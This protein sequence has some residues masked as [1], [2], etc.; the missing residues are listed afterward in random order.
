[1]LHVD[2][3]PVD[4]NAVLPTPRAC[5][6]LFFATVMALC[7]VPRTALAQVDDPS[8]A[9]DTSPKWIVLPAV[10][11]S[12]ETSMQFGGLGVVYW[13]GDTTDAVRDGDTLSRL[14]LVGIYTLKR[15]LLLRALSD[16]RFQG[17]AW[18]VVFE[19]GYERFPDRYFGIGAEPG[20]GGDED[21]DATSIDVGFDLTRRLGR[22]LHLGPR[23]RLLSTEV[24]AFAEGGRFDRGEVPGTRGVASGL[25]ISATWDQRDHPTDTR[26]G[27]YAGGAVVPFNAAFGSDRA[28]TRIDADLRGYLTLP[29]AM[30]LAGQL[31]TQF[32]PGSPGFADMA[33]LGGSDLLRGIYE[34]HFRDRHAWALQ[35]EWRY[36]IVWRFRGVAFAGIGDT[37]PDLAAFDLDGLRWSVGGGLRFVVSESERVSA[38]VDAGYGSG[39]WGIYFNVNEAF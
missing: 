9:V 26:A 34:G 29:H 21:Y 25:G 30:V 16:L 12:P 5:L 31:W 8:E 24:T 6:T 32:N 38:R 36:P 17:G 10:A 28:F 37:A 11:Y 23:Y 33:Q 7:V 20:E 35:S 22:Y 27:W 14:G 3:Y 13:T 4:A 15:Q 18:R 1:M 39:D 19:T 2:T